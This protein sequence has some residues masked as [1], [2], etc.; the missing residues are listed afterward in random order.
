M[1]HRTGPLRMGS[2][3]AVASVVAIVLPL[4]T[5]RLIPETNRP[6]FVFAPIWGGVGF[7]GMAV[8]IVVSL[9]M[10]WIRCGVRVVRFRFGRWSR[11]CVAGIGSL[12]FVT[13]AAG[14]WTWGSSRTSDAIFTPTIWLILFVLMAGSNLCYWISVVVEA[15]RQREHESVIAGALSK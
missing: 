11:L 3:L 8:L 5:W 4:A 9:V 12:S 6:Y 2:S 13:I 14:E 1:N 7:V 10:L 15:R